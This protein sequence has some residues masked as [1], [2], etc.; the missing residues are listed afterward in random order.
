[1]ANKILWSGIGKSV[2]ASHRQYLEWRASDG[3]K[4]V[5]FR[6]VQVEVRYTSSFHPRPIKTFLMF[7]L[8]QQVGYVLVARQSSRTGTRSAT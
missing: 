4:G 2:Q 6:C 8:Q 5:S 7:Y 3:E 1:M